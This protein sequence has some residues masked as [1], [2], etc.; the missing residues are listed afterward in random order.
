MRCAKC[1]AEWSTNLAER[2]TVCPFCDEPLI[3][4]IPHQQSVD[5]LK[6][7]IERFG[8]E[9][10]YQ[11]NRL[12]GLVKDV[13]PNTL[14]EKNIIVTAISLG[15][16]DVIGNIDSTNKKSEKL[17][18]GYELLRQSGLSENWCASI[19]FILTYPLGVDS[20]ELYPIQDETVK[21]K[22]VT[23]SFMSSYDE[24]VEDEY[25]K[26]SILE[27]KELSESG[28]VVAITEL[29]ERYYFGN[30][31]DKNL[32]V[33]LSYFEKA[34]EA[35]YPVAEFILGNLYDE[36]LIV[37]Q[38]TSLAF[39]YYKRAANREY[40]IAQYLLGQMYYIGQG[41]E[42]DDSESLYWILKSVDKL[43]DSDA[44]IFLSM[45]YKDSEDE[46]I[47]NEGKAFLYASK[48]AEMEDEN[49]YNLL[50]TLYELGCGIEQD[51]DKA[52]Y[53]YNLAAENG[54]EIAYLN[55]G[56]FYQM[57]IGV[58]QNDEKAVEYFQYGAN[59]GNMYCLNALGMCYKNGTGV[60]KNSEK[61][62][63]LFLA[64]AYAG[65]FAGEYNTGL[66]YDEGEGVT[67]D[68]KEAQKWF[69]LAAQHG[70]SKA[71]MSL[72]L[73]EEK[74]ALNGTPDFGAAFEWYLKAAEVGDNPFA[75]WLV[76]NCYSQGL[77]GITI[78][79]CVA[80]E[81]YLKAAELGQPTAQN[82]VA[83]D[84]IKGEI[85]DLDYDL[86]VKWFEEAISQNDIYALN[87]YGTLLLNGEG[88]DRNV[89]RAFFM[90]EHAS[91]L[92]SVDA[93]CNLGIC[94]FEGWGTKRDLD[95]ALY[96]LVNSYEAGAESAREYLE[97][98]FKEK[99]GT[100]VKKG[101]LGRVP[102]PTP[103]P[104]PTEKIKCD[105]GCRDFCKYINMS[106]AEKLCYPE[107]CC[108]CE[109]LEGKVFIKN[110]CPFYKDGI[111]DMIKVLVD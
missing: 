78:D 21:S 97:K 36:G 58:S 51:Y 65:N 28:D 12:V 1:G 27:L 9:I 42:K 33:A 69:A 57:G 59:A 30:E 73:Y 8:A 93:Q 91:N 11:E 67:E 72:G 101:I 70:C 50:G 79:R 47:R 45:I 61:A 94:Y 85:V 19:L 83:C 74:G 62:F 37:P 82:N 75:M 108:Y 2:M 17:K 76:G 111:S 16:A 80:F 35:K 39:E 46:T 64:S 109:L 25:S 96:Y 95:K 13:L 43:D 24:R 105:G 3:G 32:M 71:M 88:I 38:N 56:A 31:V 107:E 87:N 106:I 63:E 26:K 89:Q 92:G 90:F 7:I 40:P 49:A 29:G 98:G 14:K 10:Y 68:K 44:Y 48:A 54:V 103:L 104:P 77:M 52:L 6:M 5:A 86:G 66:A 102:A 110:N 18:K 22:F 41:C 81:W 20:T 100:W 53:Y 60:E 4:N 15:I 55:I 23:N 84:Y 34:A 99:N